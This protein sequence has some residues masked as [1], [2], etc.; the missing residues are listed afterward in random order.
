MKPYTTFLALTLGFAVTS[1]EAVSQNG[2]LLLFDGETGTEFAG[3]L[4]C[5]RYDT[6]SVCNKYGD[7]GSRYS[8]ASIWNRYGKFGS[9]YETN[10]PW[11]KYG[12][13]LRIVDSEG[14]YYGRFTIGW[15]DRSRI[16]LVSEIATAY[17]ELN[18]LEALRDLLCE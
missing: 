9:K 15:S 2:G 17:E 18:D 10:S 7:H 14:N 4:N 12:E 5:S 1:S 8:D 6:A 16:P 13:G 3:C 11:N